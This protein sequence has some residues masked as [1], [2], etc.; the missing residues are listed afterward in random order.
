MNIRKPIS[1]AA[2]KFPDPSILP[3][4]S[5]GLVY[6]GGNLS[7]ETLIS[8]YS[9][10]IFPWPLEEVYPLFWFCPQ[11]RGVLDFSELHVP[12]SLAKLRR[13]GHYH[14]TFN[15]SFR[16]VMEECAKQ[17][18]PGQE[19]TWIIPSLFSAYEDFHRAGYAHSIECW[20]GEEL[21]GGLYGVFV[22]GVFA[23]ESMFHREPNTS[24][25][26]LIEMALRLKAEGFQWM[27]IQ[28]IT[29]VT[30]QLGGH[31]ISRQEFLTRLK[32]EHAKNPPEKFVF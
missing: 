25:L 19:G 21:V 18:R 13:Q 7:I 4:D 5:D 28:M 24:K 17:P 6:I 11:P 8:A 22:K 12:R 15:Q 20:R 26:C 27:D 14:F 31:Y 32:I 30:E 29:P 10:G 3:E 1:S 23:G 9:A 2:V 16:R